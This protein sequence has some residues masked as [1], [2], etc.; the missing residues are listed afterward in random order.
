MKILL[1]ERMLEA[2]LGQRYFSQLARNY[3]QHDL[4]LKIIIAVCSSAAVASWNFWEEPALQWIWQFLT[5]LTTILAI[6]SP[7]LNLSDKYQKSFNISV[8]LIDILSQYETLWAKSKDMDTESLNEQM[9]VINQASLKISA[10]AFNL[11]VNN[12]K[13][14]SNIQKTITKA[15]GLNNE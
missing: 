12:K 14:V 1:W 13:M 11:N 10:D 9:Q 15:R 3:R 8:Q 7:I 2:D 5:C 4:S 6:T